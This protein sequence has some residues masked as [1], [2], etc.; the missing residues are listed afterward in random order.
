MFF[1]EWLA[2]RRA[3]R[4]LVAAEADRLIAAHGRDGFFLV[5]RTMRDATADEATKE[6]HFAVAREIDRRL[7]IKW[8]PDT[9]TRYLDAEKRRRREAR[10]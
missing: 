5:H 9:A 4:K 1:R 2:R 6:L 8:Q 3:W 10:G 7:Q